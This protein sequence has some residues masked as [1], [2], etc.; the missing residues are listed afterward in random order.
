MDWKKI[1]IMAGGVGLA[2]FTGGTSLIA[3]SAINGALAAKQAHDA[4]AG[5]G[6]SL[7][8]GGLTGASSYGAGGAGGGVMSA[9]KGS[10]GTAIAG[11]AGA[12]LAGAAKGKADDRAAADKYGLDREQ[13]GLT[14][15]QINERALADRARL[16]LDQHAQSLKSGESAFQN[17]LRASVVQNF[18]PAARPNGV[19][20]ISFIGGGPSAGAKA[21]A[22]AMEHEAMQR[23]L[24]GEQF[25]P[26]AAF[27][28][29]A[30]QSAAGPQKAGTLEN[31][32]GILGTGLSGYSGIT[33][34]LRSQSQLDQIQN[35]LGHLQNP[36]APIQTKFKLPGEEIDLP[37]VG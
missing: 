21:A 25:A 19:A 3:A 28:P 12:A 7:L 29:Y 18:K 33:R 4:G 14:A 35:Q 22:G 17:A 37:K 20:N 6:G 16:D 34:D 2:P 24:T 31:V 5:L 26:Q 9:L 10:T 32:M 36:P 27:S 23:L 8:A 11:G 30:L 15:A 13:L 1:A